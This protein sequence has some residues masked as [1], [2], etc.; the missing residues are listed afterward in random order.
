MGW[1]LFDIADTLHDM[2]RLD[3]AEAHNREAREQLERV[4]DRFGLAQTYVYEGKI[5]RSRNDLEG[6]ERA[7]QAALAIFEEQNME[8]DIVEALLRLGEV[9]ATRENWAR[10]RELLADLDRRRLPDLRPDLVHDQEL[11]RGRLP[12]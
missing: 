8:A 11:L 10:V 3:E 9:E 4:G 2:N 1:A 6:A 5:R 7:L 12:G